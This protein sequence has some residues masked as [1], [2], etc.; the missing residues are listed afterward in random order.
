MKKKKNKSP[1]DYIPF[2]SDKTF[3]PH[4]KSKY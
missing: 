4:D 3:S 1:S 2:D